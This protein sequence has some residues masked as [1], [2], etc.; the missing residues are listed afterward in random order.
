MMTTVRI[1]R[2]KDNAY[3]GTVIIDDDLTHD[4]IGE[5]ANDACGM[6][7][8]VAMGEWDGPEDYDWTGDE[9]YEVVD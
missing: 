9:E 2:H 5:I 1:T 7:D 8:V 6:A 3:V 4:A